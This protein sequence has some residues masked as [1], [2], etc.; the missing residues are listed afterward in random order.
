MES[1]DDIDLQLIRCLQED[2]RAAYAKIARTVNVSET[3]VRRRVDGL[4][5]SRAITLAM[6]PDLYTLGYR[7]SAMVGVKA[8]LARVMA[9]ADTIRSFP[10]VTMVA[11]ILGRYDIL[12]FVAERSLDDL[13]RFMTEQIAPIRGI[14]STETLVAPRVLKVLGDWRIPT[15][16]A[17][18]D[19]RAIAPDGA[20]EASDHGRAITRITADDS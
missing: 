3:T 17:P 18:R 8:D 6:L 9:I 5:A 14:R 20:A 13:T 10:E 16:D 2:P 4:L 7:A 1:V 11:L 12:F 19:D 15:N